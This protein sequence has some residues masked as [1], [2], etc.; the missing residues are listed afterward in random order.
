[1]KPKKKIINKIKGIFLTTWGGK[2]IP[3]SIG[4]RM[5]K[6]FCGTTYARQ[7]YF[8]KKIRFFNTFLVE[9]GIG[10][11][12][13]EVLNEMLKKSF[14][15]PWRLAAFSYLSDKK[16]DRYVQ[17]SNLKVF[18]ESYKK[19]K[20]VILLNSH[21][22]QA[23]MSISLFSR[24]GYHNLYTI[25]GTSGAKKAKFTRL[26]PNINTNTLVFD[27]FSSADLFKV[28]M[29]AKHILNDGGIIHLLGDGYHGKSG[30]T[31]PFIGK[32]RSFRMSYAELALSTEADIIPIFIYAQKNDHIQVDLYPSL[33]KGNEEMSKEERIRSIVKQYVD[34]LS[35][36]WMESPQLINPGH[37]EA[38][39][40]HVD[41]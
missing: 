29:E 14:I 12:N 15:K 7:N 34:L 11:V 9:S 25:L 38:Y 39:L 3:Y 17:I 10:E 40:N 13:D 23:E 28:L 8:K 37:I 30:I 1:M 6:Y 19:G 21:F 41:K 36:K 35:N 26:N 2:R 22:G 16:L 27:S 18:E 5:I 24:I 4:S 20:G 31:L 33:D 32:L